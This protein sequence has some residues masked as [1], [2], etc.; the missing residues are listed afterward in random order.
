MVSFIFNSNIIMLMMLFVVSSIF[1]F[2]L[3]YMR[4]DVSSDNFKLL[5]ILFLGLIIFILSSYGLLMF[6]GWERIGV[7]SIILI[8]Y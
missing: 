1:T 2:V 6:I 4:R 8:G 7:I 5:K 3:Y